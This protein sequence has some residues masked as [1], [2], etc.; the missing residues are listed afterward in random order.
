MR[1]LG[2]WIAGT[3]LTM[4]WAGGWVDSASSAAALAE[5]VTCLDVCQT[6]EDCVDDEFDVL[7][8]NRR[9]RGSVGRE[10]GAEDRLE[11]CDECLGDRSCASGTF[12]CRDQC[13]GILP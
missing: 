13:E 1:L 7:A 2:V 10:Q 5:P 12:Y 4:T 9:C 3:L 8:C 6:Y 11:A